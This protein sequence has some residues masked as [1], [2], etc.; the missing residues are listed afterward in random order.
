MRWY[1]RIRKRAFAGNPAFQAAPSTTLTSIGSCCCSEIL[2]TE[3][4]QNSERNSMYVP[5]VGRSVIDMGL[6]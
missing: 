5:F 2:L 3:L 4:A 1:G 6:Q